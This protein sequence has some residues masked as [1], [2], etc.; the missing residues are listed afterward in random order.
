MYAPEISNPRCM[1]AEDRAIWQNIGASFEDYALEV[2]MNNEF[3]AE[4][5]LLLTQ[6][7]TLVEALKASIN[8]MLE[9]R[10]AGLMSWWVY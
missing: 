4:R 6:H 5:A 7:E 1:T 9:F 10:S 8:T 2:A 3:A